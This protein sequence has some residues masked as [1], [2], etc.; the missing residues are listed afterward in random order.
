MDSGFD[1]HDV[2]ISGSATDANRAD[3]GGRWKLALAAGALGVS[4]FAVVACGAQ[5]AP[6]QGQAS[7][8]PSSAMSAPNA[9]AQL[10]LPN[11]GAVVQQTASGPVAVN[12]GAG[13]QAVIRPAIVNGQAISQVDCVP[14]PAVQQPPMPAGYGAPAGYVAPVGYATPV[15][16]AAPPAYVA[17]APVVARPVSYRRASYVTSDDYVQY[18]PHRVQRGRSVQ[19]SAVIIGSSAGIGAGIGAAIGGGK[20]ALI[21]A[22]LGGGGAAIWDQ[23]TRRNDR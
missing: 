19:K 8:W 6:G 22:A 5:A 10:P 23:A 9:P 20:G 3:R 2:A 4:A 17:P 13:L 11:A 1:K 16:Y 14:A 18:R 21:G 7:A 15:S 12:C